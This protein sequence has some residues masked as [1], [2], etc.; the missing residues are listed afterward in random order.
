MAGGLLAVP[1]AAE[2]QQAGKV[3][4]IGLIS[5]TDVKGDEEFFQRL[6]GLA[7]LEGRNL[8]TERRYSEGQ[9]ERFSEFAAELVRLKVDIIIVITMPAALAV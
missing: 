3:W 4:R 9:A 2:A 7:Y 8:V 6:R 1:L 5:V